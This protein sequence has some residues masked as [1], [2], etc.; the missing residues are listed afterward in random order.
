MEHA[1]KNS[2]AQ[3]R[4]VHDSG[5][6]DSDPEMQHR[7]DRT[8]LDG[9]QCCLA[10]QVAADE[11]TV[12]LSENQDAIS[13]IMQKLAQRLPETYQKFVDEGEQQ[14][15]G[16]IH[17]RANNFAGNGLQFAKADISRQFQLV[18]QMH[19]KNC[20]CIGSVAGGWG[21]CC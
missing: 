7:F 20:C 3:R 17:C 16:H 15:R 18:G 10:A 9:A 5:T 1:H 21:T 4:L 14:A 6:E 12:Q 11:I 13:Q 8:S 2:I 19:A